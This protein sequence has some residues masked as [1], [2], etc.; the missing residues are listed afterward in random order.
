M[1]QKIK[2]VKF[3]WKEIFKTDME[4]AYRV[5]CILT[6]D[7]GKSVEANEILKLHKGLAIFSST[8]Q[9][10][11]LARITEGAAYQNAVQLLRST[12]QFN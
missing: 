11:S 4:I 2:Q 7:D 5:T 12:T 1:S 10:H 8:D 3:E 9:Q 6:V